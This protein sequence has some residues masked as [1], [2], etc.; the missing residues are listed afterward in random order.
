MKGMEEKRR[1]DE[2]RWFILIWDVGLDGFKIVML[3]VRTVHTI[4]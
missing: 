3:V 1:Q 4:K 2:M